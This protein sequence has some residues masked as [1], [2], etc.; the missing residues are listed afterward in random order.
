MERY[1]IQ[2]HS[3]EI[4]EIYEVQCDND[5]P[6]HFALEM[7]YTDSEG[8]QDNLTAIVALLRA[9]DIDDETLQSDT[10]NYVT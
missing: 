1:L 4:N 6:C 2:L 10:L 8:V 9:N 7:D 5:Q 3:L